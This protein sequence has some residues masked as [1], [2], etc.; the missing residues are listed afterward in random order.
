MA[1]G[2]EECREIEVKVEERTETDR[3]DNTKAPKQM[4]QETQSRRKTLTN[5]PTPF[6]NLLCCRDVCSLQAP[7]N[8]HLLLPVLNTAASTLMGLLLLLLTP[9][10]TADKAVWRNCLSLMLSF[11]V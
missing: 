3:N 11:S 5:E 9:Q 8:E 4:S 7:L 6:I 10:Q 2:G 1:D